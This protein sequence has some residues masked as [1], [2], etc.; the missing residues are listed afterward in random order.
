MVDPPA[1]MALGL[2]PV[3]QSYLLQARQMQALSFAVHIPLVCFGIAFPVMILCVEALYLRSGDELYRVLARRWTKVMAA[4][5]AIGV[6]TGTILSFEM[7]LLWPNFTATFGSVFGLGFAVEGFSFFLEAI[8]IG[9]YVYGWDRLSPRAHFASGIPVAIAGFIGS[10]MVI[11]VNAW[12]NH[13]SGFRLQDGRAVDVHPFR[14]LFENSYLWHELVHMYVAGYLVTGFVLAGAYAIGRLRG[15]WGRY[16][17]TALAIPL[18]VAALA[19]PVQVLVGDW[20]AREVAIVQ[21]VKLAAL[22]GL[23]QS[24]RGAPTH[25]LG[26]YTDGQVK[27]GIRIPKLLSLLAFHDPNAT[28]RGL[29][30]VPAEDRPPVNVVRVA[31]Q[32]MVGIGTLL[33]LLG[34]VFLFVRVRRKRLPESRWFYIALAVAGPA[35]VVALISGWVT[36]EVG[37]Q[38]WVVYGVMRTSQAVTGAGGIPVGY[39]TLVVVYLGVGLAVAWILRRLASQ[40]LEL[41]GAP[42]PPTVEAA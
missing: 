23:G 30:T 37:R 4:L 9:I 15:R 14:A 10:L 13:P 35:S 20:A 3:Q 38:P 39:V 5:F 17:R 33:A 6:I 36:T 19:A 11:A 18:T 8:F 32:T 28:V 27:Y 29:D 26:W 25:I 12:M 7:G 41:G 1:I 42:S 34:M 31:F 16:E 24:T 40:P 22:E 21:P 2:A